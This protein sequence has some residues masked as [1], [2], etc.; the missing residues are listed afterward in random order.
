MLECQIE[1]NFGLLDDLAT[2][3]EDQYMTSGARKQ[4]ATSNQSSV[5]GR[6]GQDSHEPDVDS[7]CLLKDR[8]A[9]LINC[10]KCLDRLEEA[11]LKKMARGEKKMASDLVKRLIDAKET[12]VTAQDVWVRD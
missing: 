9:Q 10:F 8:N 1:I 11:A 3:E 2:S 6:K 5:Q 4:T 12:G 7:C